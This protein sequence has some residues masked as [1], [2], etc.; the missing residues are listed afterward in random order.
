[1]LGPSA[2]QS[3]GTNPISQAYVE[4]STTPATGLSRARDLPA[5]VKY[6]LAFAECLRQSVGDSVYTDIT[7]TRILTSAAQA[8]PL[9]SD[10]MRNIGRIT[11]ASILLCMSVLT[12]AAGEI[13]TGNIFVCRKPMQASMSVAIANMKPPTTMAQ[14]EVERR[15]L[16]EL[17]KEQAENCFYAARVEITGGG[18]EKVEISNFG[19]VRNWCQ[20]FTGKV[21]GEEVFV[22]YGSV[23]RKYGS[24]P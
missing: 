10:L 23:N 8:S 2:T 15:K 22:A 12:S 7:R 3:N 24:C 21:N 11:I 20:E 4:A 5:P 16:A 19:G 17:Q 14:A 1:M 6:V 18:Q 13:V 9:R